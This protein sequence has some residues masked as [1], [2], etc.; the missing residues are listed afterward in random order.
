MHTYLH[1]YTHMHVYVYIYVPMYTYVHMYI[2]FDFVTNWQFF[3]LLF[4]LYFKAV[5]QWTFGDAMG[6]IMPPQR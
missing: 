5:H 6:R 4:Y 2:H 3:L 1:M